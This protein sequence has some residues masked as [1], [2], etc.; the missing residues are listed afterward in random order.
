MCL[1]EQRGAKVA[2]CSV[3]EEG[4][5]AVAAVVDVQRGKDVGPGRG[6]D[7]Q[8]LL[9]Q[10][11]ARGLDRRRGAS[12]TACRMES[13]SS[14]FFSEQRANPGADVPEHAEGK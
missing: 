6:A 2:L 11:A 4:H 5:H 13:I 8:A 10:E 12:P 3:G 14:S 1:L 9:A 7:Q